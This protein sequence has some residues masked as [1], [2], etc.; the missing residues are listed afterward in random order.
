MSAVPNRCLHAR[1]PASEASQPSVADVGGL[2]LPQLPGRRMVTDGGMETDLTFHHGVDRFDDALARRLTAGQ[3]ESLR[4]YGEVR[5]TVAG[6]VLFREGDRSYD[7][8]VILTGSV[9]VLDH[10]AGEQRELA[11]GG[12]G[13]HIADLARLRSAGT[14]TAIRRRRANSARR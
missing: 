14:V 7:F 10:E 13:V 8:I 1:L 4:P 5:E 3:L 6:Q 9:T 2:A 11:I 12:P